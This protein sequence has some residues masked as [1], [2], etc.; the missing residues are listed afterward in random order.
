MNT[1]V[2]NTRQKEDCHLQQCWYFFL[3]P[4]IKVRKEKEWGWN[5]RMGI[6]KKKGKSSHV[7][8][9]SKDFL[10]VPA[11]FQVISTI[12]RKN[13]CVCA[14]VCSMCA[15]VCVLSYS[16]MSKGIIDFVT[17]VL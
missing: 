2:E 5:K 9:A 8:D 12:E 7:S 14:H 1:Q 6:L 13:M 15:R 4:K 17:Q 11:K 16:L 3:F 10:G